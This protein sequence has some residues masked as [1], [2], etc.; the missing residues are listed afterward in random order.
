MAAVEERRPM[1]AMVAK[2]RLLVVVVFMVVKVP[3]FGVL[4]AGMVVG[5]WVGSPE[6]ALPTQSSRLA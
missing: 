2:R 4:G 1:A 3:L 5:V 6:I